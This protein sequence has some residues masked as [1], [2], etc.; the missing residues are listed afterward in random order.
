MAGFTA[1]RRRITAVVARA[2]PPRRR[3]APGARVAAVRR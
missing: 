3:A 2:W 1:A